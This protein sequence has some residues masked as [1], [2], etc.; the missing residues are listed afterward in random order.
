MIY[1]G[2]YMNKNLIRKTLVLSIVVFF[3]GVGIHPAYA[4]DIKSTIS[5]NKSLLTTNRNNWDYSI[6]TFL[7]F[8]GKIENLSEDNDYYYFHAK[9]LMGFG[10]S[11]SSLDGFTLLPEFGINREAEI[12]KADFYGTINENYIRG[13]IF[14][15]TYIDIPGVSV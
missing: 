11:Y 15:V 9:I 8:F 4:I 7:T 3:I 2:G 14:N 12:L 10:F 6:L 1:E 5:D 13:I